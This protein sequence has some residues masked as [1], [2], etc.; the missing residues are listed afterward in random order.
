MRKFL[1]SVGNAKLLGKVNGTLQ[2]IADV[3]TLTESTLSFANTMEEIRAGQG[4]QLIGR[5]AHDSGMTVTLTSAT[6]DIDYVA[7]QVGATLKS[8]DPGVNPTGLYLE[9]EALKVASGNITLTKTPYAIGTACGLNEIFVWVREKGCNA[10]QEWAAIH[11]DTASTTVNVS[12]KFADGT[13]LCVE[14][15]VNKPGNR[16]IQVKSNFIPAELVLILTTKLFAGDANAAETG[17]PIGEVTVKIPRFQLDG[18]FDLSMAMS[19]AATVSL[20]GT[21]LAVDNGACDGAGVYAEIVEIID[22]VSLMDNLMDIVI[23]PETA[24]SSGDVPTVYGKFLNGSIS[25]IPAEYCKIYNSTNWKA[26][27]DAAL[28]TGTNTVVVFNGEPALPTNTGTAIT[29]NA[30]TNYSTTDE[31]AY[32]YAEAVTIS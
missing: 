27:A 25:E 32:Y 15:F 26:T 6:F 31:P 28:K 18:Q 14:Y 7:M 8:N 10:D 1:A 3:R 22:S 19:A 12:G 13:D 30:K 11:L 9:P 24:D 4:A 29:L 16:A 20:Q 23:D 17:R 21:A 5:F 2:H